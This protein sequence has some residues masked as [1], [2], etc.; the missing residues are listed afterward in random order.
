MDLPV[1][2]SPLRNRLESTLG[3]FLEASLDL[4][5][6]TSVGAPNECVRRVLAPP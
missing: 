3:W 5:L 6:S 1:S 4:C 2:R